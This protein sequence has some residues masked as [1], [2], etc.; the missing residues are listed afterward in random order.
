MFCPNCRKE[1]P[2]GTK[3][4]GGCGTPIAASQAPIDP[5]KPVAP[6][7]PV[8]PVRPAAPATGAPTAAPAKPAVKAPD[9][10]AALGKVTDIFQKIPKNVLMIGGI[11]LVAILVIVLAVNIF[12]GPKEPNY[13]MYVK[14]DQVFF[15]TLKGKEAGQVTEDLLDS[16]A[17]NYALASMA[18]SYGR[19]AH[20]TA[21]GKTLF[22][23]DDTD[24]LFYRSL[25]NLKKEPV[26]LDS[27]VEAFHVSENGKLV[28]YVTDDG[29]LMQ[30]NLKKDTEI[31][32]EVEDLYGISPDGKI[33]YFENADGEVI[34]WNNGKEEE[35][36]DDIDLAYVSKDYKT[37]YYVNDDM[38]L[39]M[40][41]IGK[42]EQEIAKE[43][44]NAS[45]ITEDG[46]FFYT[47]KLDATMG[48]YFK[49]ADDYGNEDDD[50]YMVQNLY[51]FN[52]SKS[53]L[54]AENA[55]IMTTASADDYVAMMYTDFGTLE[56]DSLSYEE[57]ME[58]L[59]KNDYDYNT[60]VIELLSDATGEATQYIA[61][62]GKTAKTELEDVATLRI[63]PDGKTMYALCDVD[64]EKN[65]GTL[66]KASISGN[67]VKAFKELD[68]DVYTSYMGFGSRSIEGEYVYDNDLYYF[69][70]VKEGEGD[71]CMNGK[72]ADSDVRVQYLSYNAAEDMLIYY[73]DYKE[74]K[75]EGTL[76]GYN[77]KKAIEI[78]SDV[79]TYSIHKDGD[80]AIGYDYNS[81]KGEYNL[82]VYTGKLKE[83]AEDVHS[84]RFTAD[85]DILYLVDYNTEKYKGDLGLYNGKAKIIDEDVIGLISLYACHYETGCQGHGL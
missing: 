11:A 57:Y 49:D 39:L 63:S 68:S 16:D 42:D 60:A 56:E 66:Y 74:D 40:K 72:V 12:G 17:S 59:Q 24:V 79:Y 78:A 44:A 38:D 4:C 58:L 77:G 30:H 23:I 8:V 31:A 29:T 35:L 10:K 9:A 1:L 71:L 20:M 3:F 50:M 22:Y 65:E 69:K 32:D 73:V 37:V 83:V 67:K 14:D 26:K 41:K 75:G 53:N 19:Y 70:D 46:A 15:N 80:I 33:I 51:Y 2:E 18:S 47:T 64:E 25:S 36:G 62:N 54:V 28:T 5:V 34:C 21:D 52:G 76:K 45:G 13:A 7:K 84:Y 6:V 85:G 55:Y 61:I 82:A 81:E 48:D 27:G 43:I